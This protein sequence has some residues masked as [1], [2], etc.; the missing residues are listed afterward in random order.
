M[1]RRGVRAIVLGEDDDHL[2]FARYTLLKLGFHG[3]EVRSLG[4][5][6]A[7]G[8]GDQHV[9]KCYAAEVRLHRRRASH[10]HVVL[11]VLIDADTT[12]VEDRFGQLASVLSDAQ[13]PA[14]EQREAIIIWVPKRHIETWIAYLASHGVNETDDFKHVAASLS[15]RASAECFATLLQDSNQRRTDTPASMTVAFEESLRLPPRV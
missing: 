11:L 8:A 10:Q 2:R 12:S 7:R 14:H 4:V 1:G 5:P 3:R 15:R 9:K 6:A 13:L